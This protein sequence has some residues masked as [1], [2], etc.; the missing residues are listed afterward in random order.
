MNTKI[1]LPTCLIRC[2]VAHVIKLVT[3][4]KPLQLVDKRVK[5]FLIRSIAQMVLSDDLDD[6]KQ[7]LQSF[8]CLIYSKTD[9]CLE[10]G[11]TTASEKGRQFLRRRIAT[12]IAEQ[13][14]IDIN[15]ESVNE[16]NFEDLITLTDI[17]N[18]F[19]KMTQNIS[20][21][22][23]NQ[24]DHEVGDHDNMYFLPA[25]APLVINL[26]TYIPLW[27]GVMCSSFKYGDIPPS[28]A[29]IESQF[30]DLKNRVLKHVNNM[31]MRIDDFV[32]LHI[33]SLDGTMKLTNASMNT[34][35][36]QNHSPLTHNK[37]VQEK[38]QKTLLTSKQSEII[39]PINT[40]SSQNTTQVNTYYED[41]N[42]SDVSTSTSIATSN[43]DDIYI[44]EPTKI[45]NEPKNN[46]ALL[47]DTTHNVES[48]ADILRINDDLSNLDNILNSNGPLLNNI[49]KST[50][51]SDKSIVN[52]IPDL[53][54]IPLIENE[55]V[56]EEN[57]GNILMNPKKKKPIYL[58]P[59]RE[60]LMRNLNSKA[61]TKSIGL[62]Q[63]GNKSRFKSL[64]L[65]DGSYVLSNTCAFDSV[66]QILAVAYCDS[67]EYGRYVDEKKNVNELWHLVSALLRDGLTVQ[68]YRKRAKILKQFYPVEPMVNGVSYLY[69]EQAVDNLLIKLLGDDE[70]VEIVRRCSSCGYEHKDKKQYLT[71]CSRKVSYKATSR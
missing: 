12:G 42:F 50:V 51:K 15:E 26:C 4:W 32:K 44:Q 59:N 68:T 66:I 33:Q 21:Q 24:V 67:D 2:D 60:I 69:V 11:L 49:N 14:F 53:H 56:S 55:D 10:N 39:H 58:T 25:V 52:T 36:R 45:I 65:D 54:A 9:G 28:S 30:N 3:T 23:Q 47:Y 18:P 6:M 7:L 27:S 43:R 19:H 31:P 1:D 34:L 61:K 64:I 37:K 29:P 8:F 16:L 17:E 22:C 5:D 13:Y 48:D 63:N 38:S 35:L 70:S 57:W 41:D 40:N 46:N 71:V 20:I 62:I